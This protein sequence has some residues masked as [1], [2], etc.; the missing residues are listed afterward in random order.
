MRTSGRALVLCSVAALWGAVAEAGE[1][2]GVTMPEL[3][4]IAGRQLR[5]NGMGLRK[6]RPSALSS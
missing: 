2:S 1:V 6:E 4:R 3:V 5:L